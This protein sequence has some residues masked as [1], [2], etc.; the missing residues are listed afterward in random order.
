MLFEGNI[1]KAATTNIGFRG[2]I[3]TASSSQ[4]SSW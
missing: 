3:A 1:E 4:S 2:V